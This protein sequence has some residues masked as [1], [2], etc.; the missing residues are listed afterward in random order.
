MGQRACA[1]APCQTGDYKAGPVA[2]A[3]TVTISPAA[4]GAMEWIRLAEKP[5]L[6]ILLA[7]FFERKILFVR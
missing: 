2:S 7:D 3:A 5:W 1:R 4:M 6:K